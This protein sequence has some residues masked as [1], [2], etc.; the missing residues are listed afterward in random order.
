MHDQAPEP[1]PGPYTV[2][3]CGPLL[4]VSAP[5]GLALTCGCKHPGCPTPPSLRALQMAQ[6]MYVYLQLYARGLANAIAIAAPDDPRMARSRE[7]LAMVEGILAY[8]RTGDMKAL[9][10]ASRGVLAHDPRPV[11]PCAAAPDLNPARN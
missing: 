7:A 6:P 5:D 1:V 10:D 2:D 3:L 9:S 11:M 4:L 8:V